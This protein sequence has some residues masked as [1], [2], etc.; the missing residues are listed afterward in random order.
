M[1]L[2][3]A[4]ALLGS[5]WASESKETAKAPEQKYFRTQY[6]PAVTQVGVIPEGVFGFFDPGEDATFLLMVESKA[7]DLEYEVSVKDDSGR[8]VYHIPRKKLE[9]SFRVP[10]QPCGYYVVDTDIFAGGKKAYSMQSAF[11]VNVPP[12]KRPSAPRS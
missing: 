5:A 11:A 9:N 6:T 12:A 1:L 3:L 10:G 2:I 8:E 4:A 7:K